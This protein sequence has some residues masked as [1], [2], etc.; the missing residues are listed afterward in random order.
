MKNLNLKPQSF[1]FKRGQTVAYAYRGGEW[2]IERKHPA[3]RI[4]MS[5]VRYDISNGQ[6]TLTGCRDKD[7]YPATDPLYSAFVTQ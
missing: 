7:I 5:C 2:K 3:D 1:N 6:E 4:F